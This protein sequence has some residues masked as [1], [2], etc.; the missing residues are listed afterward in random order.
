MS[1]PPVHHGTSSTATGEPLEAGVVVVVLGA[2]GGV[3]GVVDGAMGGVVELMVVV[4]SLLGWCAVR[5][6]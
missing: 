6:W 2:A 1:S 4:E 5:P 3:T